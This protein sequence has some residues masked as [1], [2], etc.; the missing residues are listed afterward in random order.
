MTKV[1]ARIK[2]G[3]GNQL[4]CYAAARRLALVNQTELVIDDVTGFARDRQY[5]RKYMLD[6]FAIPARK[7]TAAERLE[8]F[9]R[10]RR[11]I[12]KFISRQRTFLKRSYV[13]QEGIEFDPRLLEF[14]PSG[15]VYLDGL[16]QS[17]GYF[18]DLEKTIREDLRIIH[19]V[20]TLNLQLAEKIRNCQVAVALHVRWFDAPGNSSPNNVSCNYYQRAIALMENKLSLPHYFLFSDNAEAAR[21]KLVLPEGRVSFISHNQGDKNA[22]AD[23]WLMSL[24]RHFITA[25]STF[26]WWGAW[27]GESEDSIVL[28][29]EFTPDGGVTSWCF[30]GLIPERWNLIYSGS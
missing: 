20:D 24:C 10:Y 12:E 5:Q 13:E 25:N 4:F 18:K 28:V 2:G 27:L 14:R 6:H 30:K 11:G 21:T 8:P 17:E 3:L 7:A 23:L 9:E 19:P 26:S 22:Y 29:P 16:W 1:I 15:K